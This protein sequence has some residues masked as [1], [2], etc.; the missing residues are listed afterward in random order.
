MTDPSNWCEFCKAHLT[1]PEDR[2]GLCFP[3]R[4]KGKGHDIFEGNTVDFAET[5]GAGRALYTHP[6]RNKSNH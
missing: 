4:L 6:D 5:D 3:C 1:E 2:P